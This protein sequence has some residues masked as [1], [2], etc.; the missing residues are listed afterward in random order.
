MRLRLAAALLVT[1]FGAVAIAHAADKPNPSGE[2]KV[3][4]DFNGRAIESTLTLKLD[5]DKLTGTN[6]RANGQSAPIQDAK[7]KDGIVSFT[8]VREQGG[9]KLPI[10]FSAKL[11]GDSMKG[12]AELKYNDEAMSLDWDAKR[13]AA[14]KSVPAKKAAATEKPAGTWK[15][16]VDVNGT[17]YEF[18]VKLKADGAKLTGT[19]TGDDGKENPLQDVACKDGTVSFTVVREQDGEKMPIKNS[20]KLSGDTIKGK[21]ELKVD[22]EAQSMPWEAKRVVEK[23]AVAPKTD[24]AQK[25]VATASP[26]GNWKLSADVNGTTYEFTVKLKLD[27]DKWTGTIAGDDGNENPL[28][29]V[30]YKDGNVLFTIVRE[31]NGEKMPMK[32]SGKLTGDTLKG[33]TD[34]QLDGEA[35]SLPWEAK[36]AK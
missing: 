22:G 17:P 5:G 24:A 32:A 13:A 36:R 6:A 19:I 33:K 3:S 15:L 35:H 11:N 4:I 29:D 27:G 25:P 1:F 7:Y 10:K 31:Q 8:I 9:E 23:A 20:G 21:A 34:F 12:K 18:T 26:A 28:Q 14:E 2:W 16:T 30:N